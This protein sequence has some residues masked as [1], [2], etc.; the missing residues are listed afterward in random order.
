MQDYDF[1][2]DSA[3]Q[4][5]NPFIASS[6]RRV[7][8]KILAGEMD[9][10]GIHVGS[11]LRGADG[12]DGGD[13]DGRRVTISHRGRWDAHDE[14]I[15]GWK[16]PQGVRDRVLERVPYVSV[17]NI[18]ILVPSF[19]IIFTTLFF[20][21]SDDIAARV[22]PFL[23]VL[24]SVILWG[25]GLLFN[26]K[27]IKDVIPMT[28]GYTAVLTLILNGAATLRQPANSDGTT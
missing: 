10:A 16:Y 15:W 25:L 17:A 8:H 7:D 21:S 18:F 9:A 14:P 11:L 22:A 28:A 2:I 5:N 27:Q 20:D 13:G 19:L 4:A 6:V 26:V 3:E 24:G 23:V 12:A 1:M